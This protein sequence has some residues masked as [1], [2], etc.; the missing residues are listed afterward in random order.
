MLQQGK[1]VI[2]E[3]K[4]E[5]ES[6]VG[7]INEAKESALGLWETIT[8]LWDWAKGLLGSVAQLDGGSKPIEVTTTAAKPAAKK[9]SRKAPEPELSYEEYK[10]KAIHEVCEHLK[11]FFEAQRQLK[12]HCRELEEQSLT[13]D[14]VADS[15]I[16]RIEIETQ[17]V[18][19]STQIREAMSWTPE[20]LGLQDMYQRFLKMYELILEEQE[21]DRQ[22]KLRI[23][24]NKRW[25]QESR[26]N[27]RIDV[28]MLA[29]A[30]VLV[31]IVWWWMMLQVANLSGFSWE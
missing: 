8:G 28:A 3:F 12:I 19:L 17:L 20:H 13:T 10:A 6:V 24:R 21:F 14:R 23:A 1:A 11:V 30:T 5:A 25:L 16:D 26:R 15:A 7:Q 18:S 9:T 29:A 4:G 27:L 31:V 2:D 22:R